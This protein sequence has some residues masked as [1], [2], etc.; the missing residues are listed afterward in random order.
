MAAPR[1]R[2]FERR[3]LRK[4]SS[5]GTKPRSPVHNK[6]VKPTAA[7]THN[8]YVVLLEDVVRHW[9]KSKTANPNARPELPCVYVGMSGLV[10]EER[11]A[12]H[13]AGVKAAQVVKKFGVRLLPK[14]FAYLNPMPYDIAVTM[15][16]ELAEDLR[17]AGYTVFGGT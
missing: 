13:K 9:R 16:R 12:N 17:R 7:G 15:E 10:P 8:V 1:K 6:N 3:T 4:F 2:A 5:Q 14:L 11:F